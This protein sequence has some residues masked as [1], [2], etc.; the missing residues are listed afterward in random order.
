MWV[1]P[2]LVAR[3]AGLAWL[4]LPGLCVLSYLTHIAGPDAADLTMFGTLVSFRV[5]EWGT[6]LTLLV[7]DITS[8]GRG[9]APPQEP[10]A[11]D[12]RAGTEEDLAYA[13]SLE[14]VY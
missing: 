5:F 13:E 14:V 9:F 8:G 10:T 1:L 2:L 12:R 6:F 4:A 7:Y 11:A 3:P